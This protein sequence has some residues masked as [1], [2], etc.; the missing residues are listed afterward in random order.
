VRR[1]GVATGAVREA[2]TAKRRRREI[3]D[4]RV[5][6]VIADLRRALQDGRIIGDVFEQHRATMTDE[7]VDNFFCGLLDSTDQVLSVAARKMTTVFT[8]A[9]VAN[10]GRRARGG[11]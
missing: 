7:E 3:R 4:A 11:R 5:A 9:V 6:V 10:P 8:G 1:I 2:R